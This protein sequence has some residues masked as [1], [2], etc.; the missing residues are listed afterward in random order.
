LSVSGDG[1]NRRD[2]DF[3]EKVFRKLKRRRAASRLRMPIILALNFG[4]LQLRA[5]TT[6]A[7][8][9]RF[10]SGQMMNSNMYQLR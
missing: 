8:S 3:A 1:E 9:T 2:F 10:A 6:V 5:A 4:N 7:L